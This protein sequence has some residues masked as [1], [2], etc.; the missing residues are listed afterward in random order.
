M[1][2]EQ[3]KQNK[4]RFIDLISSISRP[5]SDKKEFFTWLEASDFFDAPASLRY[6]GSFPGGLCA[7]SLRVY[8]NLLKLAETFAIVSETVYDL[9]ESGAPIKESVRVEQRP[10]YTEDTLKIVALLHDLNKVNLFTTY[11][12]NV[13]DEA[14]GKWNS[15]REYKYREA[16]DPLRLIYGSQEQNSEFHAHNFFPLTVEESS[17]I[18]NHL[19]GMGND[20]SQNITPVIFTKYSLA[21]L[22]HMAD[23]LASYLDEKVY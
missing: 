11:L 21:L 10:L 3:I 4:E 13:K 1:T 16:D 5:G 7:H 22:L 12:R 19:G 6:H 23:L 18:L 9:D 8:D 15:V 17:A 2:S 14:T 20:S